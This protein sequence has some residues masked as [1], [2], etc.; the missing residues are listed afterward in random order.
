MSRIPSPAKPA[1]EL[2]ADP[3]DRWTDRRGSKLYKVYVF[4]V[5]PGRGEIQLVKGGPAAQ[6]NIVG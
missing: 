6:R 1:V 5:T 4:R 3:I 2:H